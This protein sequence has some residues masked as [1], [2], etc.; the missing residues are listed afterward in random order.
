MDKCPSMALNQG[1][2]GRYL[3][4]LMG[5]TD[6]ATNAVS[7]ANSDGGQNFAA[8]VTICGTRRARLGSI[9]LGVRKT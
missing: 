3:V 9:S 8:A 2:F 5:S 1:L 4:A 6:A 7:E